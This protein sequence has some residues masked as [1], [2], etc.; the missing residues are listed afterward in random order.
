MNIA[1]EVTCAKYNTPVSGHI[2]LYQFLWR[3]KSY[4]HSRRNYRDP[5]L[6]APGRSFIRMTLR[7]TV[8]LTDSTTMWV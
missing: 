7:R 1:P 3:E 6:E 4:T 8:T 5:K 2:P